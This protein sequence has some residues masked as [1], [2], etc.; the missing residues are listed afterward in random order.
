MQRWAAAGACCFDLARGHLC[1]ARESPGA[2][3]LNPLACLAPA[4]PPCP[5]AAGAER[6]S[7]LRK[8]SGAMGTRE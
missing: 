4:R 8:V 6:F 7:L 1:L 2:G 5:R 3:F